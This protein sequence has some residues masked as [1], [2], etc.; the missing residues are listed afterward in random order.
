MQV[1]HCGKVFVGLVNGQV[2]IF[3]RDHTVNWDLNRLV[4]YSLDHLILSKPF[5]P[6]TIT[7]GTEP[8]C[9]LLP[10]SGALYTASGQKILMLDAWANSVIRSFTANGEQGGG[11]EG[12]SISGTEGSIMSLK[13]QA[14]SAASSM[15]NMASM[16][17]HMAVCGIGLWVALH[18]SSTVSLYHTE[19]FIHM[20]DINIASNVSR[21]LGGSSKRSIY[22]TALSA[23]KGL[24]WVGDLSLFLTKVT[25]WFSG[26]D[27][28][29]HSLDDPPAEAGGGA[30][31]LWQG[32]HL[33]PRTLWPSQDV[34]ATPAEGKD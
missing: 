23:A 26:G 31:H 2:Q 5:S 19:S 21:A 8:V 13:N 9:C 12:G 1:H 33:L 29:W 6:A 27:Q 24:L 18:H 7:I 20:Q 11:G 15:V 28:R 30:H 10:T 3:R 17:N 14:A 4:K 25:Q 22:V 34:P 16:V 32:K